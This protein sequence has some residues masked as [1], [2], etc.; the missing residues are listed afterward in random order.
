M[1]FS[2]QCAVKLIR[3]NE[4]VNDLDGTFDDRLRAET[5]ERLDTCSRDLER[6]QNLLILASALHQK[7]RSLDVLWRISR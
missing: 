7:P 3:M 4:V 6:V 1:C 2:I 5:I